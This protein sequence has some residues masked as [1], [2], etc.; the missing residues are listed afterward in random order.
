MK[1]KQEK[2]MSPHLVVAPAYNVP[3]VAR[4]FKLLRH[5]SAGDCVTN[6][7]ETARTLGLSRTTLIR[8]I[9]TLKSE[10]MIEPKAD[11]AGYRLGL[12]LVGLAGEALLSSDIVQA[13]GPVIARLTEELAL[14]S[15]IGV[16][17]GRDVL[18]VGR[19]TPNV[20]LVSNV[21]IGS[22]LP[23]HATTMGRIILA[24]LPR[25]AVVSLFDGVRLVAATAK[26]ATSLQALLKQIAQDAAAGI[27]WSNSNFEPGIAS[28][29]A[30]VFDQSGRVA[31]AINVTGPSAAF[32]DERKD[33]IEATVIAAASQISRRLG[34]V[35]GP[36][37]RVSGAGGTKR[38]S[39]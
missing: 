32:T 9:G 39:R 7:S 19:R 12:G 27:A 21:G 22:R 15:H 11:G 29:A 14:S 18:Y 2:A 20:H 16:L 36:A 4:A 35:A 10:Q 8:L 23:A 34:Y 26:T 1:G 33:Q 31:G 24:H 37:A 5:I 25:D 17:S 3:P 28:A 13:G 6:M 38:R 30:A